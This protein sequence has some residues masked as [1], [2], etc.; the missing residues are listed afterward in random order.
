MRKMI[1]KRM[2]IRRKKAVEKT[3]EM[4]KTKMMSKG[5]G[6][7]MIRRMMIKSQDKKMRRGKNSCLLSNQS[8]TCLHSS[9]S[10]NSHPYSARY[11][12]CQVQSTISSARFVHR[13]EILEYHTRAI[14]PHS[15]STINHNSFHKSKYHNHLRQKS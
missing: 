14:M 5:R 6:R 3:M 10:S 2:T 8:L 15:R 4:I 9:K 12:A 11:P 1:K 13:L 7:I